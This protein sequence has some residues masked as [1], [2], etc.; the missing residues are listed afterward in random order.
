MSTSSKEGLLNIR[1]S[2]GYEWEDVKQESQ[3][4]SGDNAH[5][6]PPEPASVHCLLG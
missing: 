5:L 6:I 4:P 1:D 3:T 2:A